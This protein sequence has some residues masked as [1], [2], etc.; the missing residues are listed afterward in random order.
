VER[1]EIARAFV[2]VNNQDRGSFGMARHGDCPINQ[3]T[4][5]TRLVDLHIGEYVLRSV[6]EMPV[7]SV[8]LTSR[9]LRRLPLRVS[10]LGRDGGV[11]RHTYF[12]GLE[13]PV[14]TCGAR[15]SEAV[16]SPQ[17]VSNSFLSQR[18]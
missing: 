13:Y 16:S 15:G 6:A 1:K 10:S 7:L 18:H 3:R 2:I 12:N 14:L 9:P 8:S 11:T 5:D 17:S 4:D